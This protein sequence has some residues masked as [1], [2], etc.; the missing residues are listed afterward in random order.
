MSRCA[1][2]R[3]L[4]GPYWDDETSRAEREWLD[5]HFAMCAGCRAEY[6]ELARTLAAVA[7]LPRAEAAP[8]LAE[9][10]L[11]AARRSAPVRDVVFVREGRAWA[12]LAAA[13]AAVLLTV[14]A[15]SPW[16]LRSLGGGEVALNGVPALHGQS[17]AAPGAPAAPHAAVAAVVDSLFDH[18]EDVD[19]VLD[20][21]TLRRGHVHSVTGTPK[22]IQG[23]QAIITF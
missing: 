20:P 10:V 13:A 6:E 16:L 18:S 17:V 1:R 14:A 22:G 11:A 3:Q 2:A 4:F 21:V 15:L 19:F 5:A 7:T 9:R 23:G 8:D 12:P